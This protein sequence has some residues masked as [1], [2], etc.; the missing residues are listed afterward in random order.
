MSTPQVQV[1]SDWYRFAYPP[2]MA[3]LPWAQKTEAEVDRL[4]MMLQPQG[5]ERILDLACGTGR[6]ALELTRRGFSVVGS[7][8]L[9]SNVEVARRA[10]EE[11][12][13]DVEFTQADLR[14]LDLDEEFDIVLSLNDGAVGYFESE[15]ENMKTFEVIARALRSSGR[16]LLQIA[17]VLH[18]EKHM[19]IKGWI[20]GP[21]AL[22]L[23]DHH[24]NNMTRCT[25]GT[26]ATIAV[27]EVFHGYEPIPFRKRLY[28]VDEL[29]E[30]YTSVGMSLTETYRG[31]GKAGRPR[32]TQYEVFIE[33]AKS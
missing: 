15:A 27:G 33:A 31:N 8:L 14:E 2:E 3:K 11:Q 23:I 21:G 29:R 22:E 17:N 25:E 32:N 26:T 4:L 16:H 7:E 20:E 10:A 5:G 24:W 1:P 30:I 9:E 6:H 12:S 28:S 18:A 13:L 19:P